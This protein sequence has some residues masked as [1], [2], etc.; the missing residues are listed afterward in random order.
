MFAFS[1]SS[2]AVFLFRS[3]RSF[4][5]FA[6]FENKKS[7]LSQKSVVSEMNSIENMVQ[8]CVNQ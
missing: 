2:F 7:L 1:L 6:V 4:R 8:R 5:E 3:F